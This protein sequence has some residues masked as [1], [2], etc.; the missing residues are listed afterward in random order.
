MIKV[1]A[2]K[3]R[4]AHLASTGGFTVHLGPGESRNVPLY[5]AALAAKKGCA[6]EPLSDEP[7]EPPVGAPPSDT[8][9]LAALSEAVR[10]LIEE[11]NPDNF[12]A[13]GPPR[14]AVVQGLTSVEFTS[15]ELADVY[16]E[17]VAA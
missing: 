12:T 5:F 4:S 17:V 16:A 8:E 13:N 9:R 15:K 11:G 2:P 10:L 3:D 14:K 1:T 6:I 7:G